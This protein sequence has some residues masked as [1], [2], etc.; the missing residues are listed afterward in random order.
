MKL[1]YS[2]LIALF[3]LT[4]CSI[5]ENDDD[6]NVSFT[7]NELLVQNGTNSPVYIFAV[8]QSTAATI[9]WV[10]ISSDEN[11]VSANNSRS[12]DKESITGFEEGQPVIVYYWFDPED[13]I[14]NFV[15]D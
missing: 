1:I 11:R 5:F 2:A 9:F 4:G 3:L 14:F 12:F 8:D 13:E 15:L 6:V 7:R 10:P